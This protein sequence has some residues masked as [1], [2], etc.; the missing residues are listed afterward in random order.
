MFP[1]QHYCAQITVEEKAEFIPFLNSLIDAAFDEIVP[2]FLTGV[3]VETKS[4]GTPVTPVDKHTEAILRERIEKAYPTH[5]IFGEEYGVKPPHEKEPVRYRWILDPIDG[6]KSFISNSFQFGTLIALERDSGAGFAPILSCIAHAAAGVRAIGTLDGTTMHLVN[7][8]TVIDRELH[9]R[10]CK[11]IEDAT[12][13]T[14]SH[15]TCP[16]QHGTPRIQE[17]IDRC[18]LYRT[19]GDCFGYFAVASGGA[20]IMI[21]P[22]LSYWDV[23]ALLP[24]VEGAG[25]IITSLSGGNPLK[26][27]NAICTAGFIHG[28]VIALLNHP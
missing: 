8:S 21:D 22:E 5:G 4:D 20:D 15:W 12:L 14:T 28:E 1:R 26:E 3:P 23:A 19:F 13:F 10:P 11:R 6:T 2:R 9:V 18:R 7:R 27:V 16:E 25:G 17:L 24:V